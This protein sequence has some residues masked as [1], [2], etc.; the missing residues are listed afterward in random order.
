MIEFMRCIDV[1]PDLGAYVCVLRLDVFDVCAWYATHEE[2]TL[3]HE[4]STLPVVSGWPRLSSTL[5]SGSARER[6]RTLL[7]ACSNVLCNWYKHKDRA[8]A[9]RLAS[10]RRWN[11]LLSSTLVSGS[12]RE[13]IRTLLSACS[14]VEHLEVICI[15]PTLALTS[16][17]LLVEARRN[18][19]PSSSRL[20]ELNL[21]EFGSGYDEQIMR[22]VSA[23]PSLQSLSLE[24]TPCE[25]STILWL[26]DNCRNLT[27]LGLRR[28]PVVYWWVDE[29]RRAKPEVS[30]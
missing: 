9:S 26:L 4:D 30:V 19:D 6:I 29:I 22:L 11:F 14:N 21:W 28:Y 10:A 12:A 1:R 2:S 13:R 20:I 5:V 15:D 27:K 16:L 25:F 17:E 8:L 3:L 24:G 18:V 7:S 23:N